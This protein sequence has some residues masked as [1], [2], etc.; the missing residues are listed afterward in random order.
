MRSL[1]PLLDHLLM[2]HKPVRLL[3][4]T[5]SHLVSSQELHKLEHLETP[6][7]WD[8]ASE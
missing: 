5:L 3:G 4:V 6:S 1:H 7:L 2:E 8:L